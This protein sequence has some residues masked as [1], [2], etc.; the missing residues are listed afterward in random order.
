[1]AAMYIVDAITTSSCILPVSTAFSVE[2]NNGGIIRPLDEDESL[3]LSI[4]TLSEGNPSSSMTCV[5]DDLWALL[6]SS[7]ASFVF[8]CEGSTDD[9]RQVT[10]TLQEDIHDCIATSFGIGTY[11]RTLNVARICPTV[12]RFVSFPVQPQSVQ[13][14]EG[15]V[16]SLLASCSMDEVCGAF[17]GDS[18]S[19]D[20]SLDAFG[21]TVTDFSSAFPCLWNP[22]DLSTGRTRNTISPLE[23]KLEATFNV[24][25]TST[26]GESFLGD[27][28]SF[29]APFRISITCG[30]QGEI[31]STDLENSSACTRSSPETFDCQVDANSLAAQELSSISTFVSC[32]GSTR[33]SLAL[34]VS[35][36]PQNM[37]CTASTISPGTEV[38]TLGY[39]IAVYQTCEPIREYANTVAQQC[40]PIITTQY[41]NFT[42]DVYEIDLALELCGKT[43]SN[44]H[45]S[46]QCDDQGKQTLGRLKTYVLSENVDLLCV[47]GTG[48]VTAQA[49]N[50]IE[51]NVNGEEVTNTG[52]NP[53]G[54]NDIVDNSPIAA[55]AP[56]WKSFHYLAHSLMVSI[57][58]TVLGLV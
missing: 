34:E 57:P 3:D 43:H 16:P 5:V 52:E 2:C 55:A 49:G 32:R 24:I 44:C 46:G 14:S 39:N 20:T 30:T 21:L 10:V 47:A 48:A 6:Q 25:L 28:C 17:S 37:E 29:D 12:P 4:C 42:D 31:G 33:E 54:N 50:D 7:I 26:L 35:L 56:K 8:A 11:G 36:D 23:T 9:S 13:C 18:C 40:A 51:N 15:S 41:A 45:S 1:M 58:Y 27:S 19:S 38:A 22:V 53:V